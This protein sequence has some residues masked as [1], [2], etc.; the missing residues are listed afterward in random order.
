ML[1]TRTGRQSGHPPGHAHQ[2][3]QKETAYVQH[4]Q[5]PRAGGACGRH[6]R[7]LY[8]HRGHRRTRAVADKPAAAVAFTYTAS[9]A[10]NGGTLSTTLPSGEG[11]SGQ[12]VQIAST[13][14]VDTIE[15]SLR[16][17]AWIDWGPFDTLWFHGSDK[18]VATLFGDKGD[19]MRCRF[20]LNDPERGMPGGGV[21]QCQVSNGSHID[22]RF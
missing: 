7:G 22:A 21:G 4:N 17:P 9:W 8:D 1:C 12:Y 14:T 13:S 15:P 5:T 10:R 3:R 16:D 19:V 6:A 2:P 18:V 11:F 20:R